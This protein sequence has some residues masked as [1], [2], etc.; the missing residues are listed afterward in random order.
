[1]LKYCSE[2]CQLEH[3][4]LVHSKHCKKLA[5]AKKD[6]VE[7]KNTSPMPVSIY[8]NHPFP[9][10]GLPGDVTEMLLICVKKT[11]EKMRSSGHSAFSAF[12]TGLEKLE[13]ELARGRILFWMK[14]KTNPQADSFEVD[15]AWRVQGG[16][17][18][19]L[20]GASLVDKDMDPLGLWST[21]MLFIG[22]IREH[23]T[24]GAE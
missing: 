21:L 19:P 11:L 5:A 17:L 6:E 1:M 18:K 20:E 7:G 10:D 24:R 12:P 4:Q 2:D 14:R 9:L 8:S 23:L 3:W 15:L 22:R 16:P 13:N